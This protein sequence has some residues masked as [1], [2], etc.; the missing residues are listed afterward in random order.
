MKLKHLQENLRIAAKG[1]LAEDVYAEAKQRLD[2]VGESPD[3]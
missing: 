2:R 3:E 1:P